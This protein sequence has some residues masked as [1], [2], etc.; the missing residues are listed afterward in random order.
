MRLPA[1]LLGVLIAAGGLVALGGGIVAGMA[2]GDRASRPGHN[3][4]VIASPALAGTTNEQA[5]RSRGG[6]TG[7]DG[8]GGLDGSAVRGGTMGAMR[9]GAFEVTSSGS[10]LSV[11]ATSSGRLFGIAAATSPLRAG[12]AVVVRLQTDGSASGVLRVPADLNEG[13]GRPSPTPTPT[14]TPTPASSSTP[15]R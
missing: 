11:R 15:A 12:D 4:L 14:P 2:L 10:T 1:R 9:D 3:E 8:A 7:F 5:V 13:A 6:F